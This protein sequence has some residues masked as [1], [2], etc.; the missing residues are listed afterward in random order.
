V[1]LSAKLQI[2]RY[3]TK[4]L[5]FFAPVE[6]QEQSTFDVACGFLLNDN[7]NSERITEMMTAWNSDM[8][9]LRINQMR[10]VPGMDALKR[11]S[12]V[13]EKPYT[14]DELK[15]MPCTTKEERDALLSKFCVIICSSNKAQ[16]LELYEGFPFGIHKFNLEMISRRRFEMIVDVSL[17]PIILFIHFIFSNPHSFNWMSPMM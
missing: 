3:F 11:L 7:L 14:E 10:N 13:I 15:F 17:G 9:L 12:D 16:F 5:D 6:N 1:T 2:L 8:R 4:D